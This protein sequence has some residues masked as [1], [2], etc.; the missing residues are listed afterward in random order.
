[1]LDFLPLPGIFGTLTD[2]HLALQSF[3]GVPGVRLFLPEVSAPR[4]PALPGF[5]SQKKG[6]RLH[7]QHLLD[8][9]FSGAIGKGQRGGNLLSCG[10]PWRL[11][12]VLSGTRRRRGALP[13]FKESP[14]IVKI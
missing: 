3:L 6:A 5:F 1:M 14:M 7:I 13:F 10:W 12:L 2:K 4:G 9:S 11:W 8:K